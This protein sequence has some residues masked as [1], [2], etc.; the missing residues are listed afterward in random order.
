MGCRG[1]D[2]DSFVLVIALEILFQ[3]IA[4]SEVKGQQ[5]KR[6][7][8]DPVLLIFEGGDPCKERI[9]IIKEFLDLAGM[10]ALGGRERGFNVD[11]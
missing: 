6:E 4:M 11:F 10:T 2:F 8:D 1:D 7:V 9:M 5:I 3:L